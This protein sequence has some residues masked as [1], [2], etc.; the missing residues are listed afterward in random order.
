MKIG[1]GFSR[2]RSSGKKGELCSN[3][4]SLC[5]S[6]TGGAAPGTTV[7][8]GS[9]YTGESAGWQESFMSPWILD[10]FSVLFFPGVVSSSFH[11]LWIFSKHDLA[12]F[13]FLRGH[14]FPQRKWNSHR[15]ALLGHCIHLLM[16]PSKGIG[17]KCN[18]A[19]LVSCIIHCYLNYHNPL[20]VTV[21]KLK[22]S[23]L[24]SVLWADCPPT[25][26]G[27]YIPFDWHLDRWSIER[28]PVSL[29]LNSREKEA[30]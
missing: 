21:K 14:N 17:L 16:I 7:A 19:N 5:P 24:F 9:S 26:E 15:W 27:N 30:Q 11:G 22:I 29:F 20:L 10:V 28:A 6:A 8:P 25:P 3:H 18:H 13:L 2:S 12:V 1:L 4:C 23:F